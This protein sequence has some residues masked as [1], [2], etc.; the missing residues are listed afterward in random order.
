MFI[1][2]ITAEMVMN[3]TIQQHVI[4]GTAVLRD[5]QGKT[6]CHLIEV[7]ENSQQPV[8]DDRPILIGGSLP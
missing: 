7:L 5:V 3:P 8:R 1:E 4:I 6:V 2:I